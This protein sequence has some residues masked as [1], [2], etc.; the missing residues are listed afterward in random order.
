M[1]TPLLVVLLVCSSLAAATEEVVGERVRVLF[2]DP[3]LEPFAQRVAAGADEALVALAELFA[4]EPPSVVLVLDG[5]TDVFNASAPSLPRPTVALLPLFPL[6]GETGF[7]GP[8]ALRVLL[9]HELTHNVHFAYIQRPLG[10]P[11]P[12]RVGLLG[13][14][15]APFPP[16]WFVEGVATWVESTLSGGGGRLNDARVRGL[17]ASLALEGSWPDLRDASLS[18]YAPWP[19]GQTRY[20]LGAGFI[21]HLVARHGFGTLRSTLRSYNAGGLLG[22]FSAAWSAAAGTDLGEEWEAF[23]QTL[24]ERAEVWATRRDEAELLTDSGG[25]T[26]RPMVAPDGRRLAW[27]TWPPAIAVAEL[28]DSGLVG[29]RSVRLGV[30]PSSLDWLDDETLVYTR[31]DRQANSNYAEL[32]ALDLASGR[33]RRLTVGARASFAS[34]DGEGCIWHVRDVEPGGSSLRRWCQD[35]GLTELWHAPAG[36]H[37]VGLDVSPGGRVAV[38]VWRAG[39]VDLALFEQGAITLLTDDP[40][41]DIDPSW[42]GEE[43]LR[44]ASDRSGVYEIYDLAIAEGEQAALQRRSASLGGSFQPAT[45]DV[46]VRLGPEGYELARLDSRIGETVALSRTDSVATETPAEVILPTRTY[47]P[48]ASL[49]PFAWLATDGAIELSPGRAALEVMALGQ[50][51]SGEHSYALTIGHDTALAGHLGGSHIALRY[52]LS[53]AGLAGTIRPPGSVSAALR[54]GVWPHVPH[55]GRG[56]ETAAGIE[57]DTTATLL[58]DPVFRVRLRVGLVHL[59]SAAAWQPDLR[60][61]VRFGRQFGDTFGYRT[62]GPGL[63]LTA[64]RSA[65]SDGPSVGVWADGSWYLP[66]PFGAPGTGEIA[67]RAG[68]R[69]APPVPLLLA[70]FAAVA[71]L[72]YRQSV[73]LQ[74]RYGDGRYALEQLTLELRVRLWV[75]GDVGVGADLSVYADTVLSYGA[76]VSFGVRGGYAEGWWWGLVFPF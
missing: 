34:A 39:Q 24:S 44:F 71:T 26:G 64:V 2:A 42:S 28:T 41:H 31:I 61:E 72:G 38:S 16:S 54:V 22:D 35:G 51:D 76:P 48:F 75:D 74:W 68:F 11:S 53:E 49:A 21:E 62:R 32:F 25:L 18:T 70:E 63:A 55:L 9:L 58:R 33:E 27:V 60:A 23:R 40:G 65:T 50:D 17:L 19:G 14:T 15:V 66:Q 45:G 57:V 46:F 1:R 20:L 56:S 59:Q 73:P 12:L 6:Q 36:S 5:S 43:T 30:F 52:A 4:S 69:Q 3:A 10:A 29:T 67:L 47:R 13:E 8:D 37:L 7:G